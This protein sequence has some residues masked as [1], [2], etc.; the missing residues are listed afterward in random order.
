MLVEVSLR[1]KPNAPGVRFT[2]PGL[3]IYL[4]VFIS[5]QALNLFLLALQLPPLIIN[6]MMAF[7]RTVVP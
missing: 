1:V 6:P 5:C 3:E 2:Y 7:Q 4:V